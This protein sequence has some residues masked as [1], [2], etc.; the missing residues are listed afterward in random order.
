MHTNMYTKNYSK[1]KQVSIIKNMMQKQKQPIILISELEGLR[2]YRSLFDEEEMLREYDSIEAAKMNDEDADLIVLDAGFH[3][4]HGLLF[5]KELKASRPQIP[6]IFIT[7]ISSERIAVSAF[8]TGA[9]DYFAK[10]ADL[11]S[12]KETAMNLLAV[13][14]V[15]REKRVRANRSDIYE[16]GYSL[17]TNIPPG[18]ANSI[19]F[20]DNNLRSSLGL[21]TL[22]L[23][24]G[25][26][27]FHFCRTFKQHTGL[28]PKNFIILRRMERAKKM[29]EKN[30]NMNISTIAYDVG[31]SNLAAFIKNFKIITGK[32]PKQYRQT[33]PHPNLFRQT[34]T[35]H[36]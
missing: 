14:R 34:D 20:I 25:M 19:L 35:G 17:T 8:R 18:I 16:S 13:K 11:Y 27:K 6:L 7:D 15:C 32:T 2:H 30:L 3:P 5:L 29:L 12:I 26:S 4:E 31:F 33:F 21:G 10:P 1:V 24:A 9:A 22:A 23:Q 28:T 36:K